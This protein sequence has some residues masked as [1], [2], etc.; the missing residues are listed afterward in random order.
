M[1]T[2]SPAQLAAAW[3]NLL[4]H[5]A[6][7]DRENGSDLAADLVARLL[8]PT[9]SADARVNAARRIMAADGPMGLAYSSARYVMRD[10]AR[11]NRRRMARTVSIDAIGGSPEYVVPTG[12]AGDWHRGMADDAA[13]D[14]A[15]DADGRIMRADRATNESRERIARN[16]ATSAGMMADGDRSAAATA[17]WRAASRDVPYMAERAGERETRLIREPSLATML[18]RAMRPAGHHYSAEDPAEDRRLRAAWWETFAYRPAPILRGKVAQSLAAMADAASPDGFGW[19]VARHYSTTTPRQQS[20]RMDTRESGEIAWSSLL[21]EIGAEPTTT[22]VRE[23]RRMARYAAAYATDAVRR[24]RIG[25]PGIDPRA[26][27]TYDGPSGAIPASGKV[28]TIPAWRAALVG[29]M[30]PT[31]VDVPSPAQAAAR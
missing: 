23:V 31:S 26:A 20:G 25:S 28:A 9:D 15:L 7:I 13:R 1:P 2:P 5:A 21:R 4:S 17:A 29:G 10:A 19:L 11:S 6:T 27:D 18:D 16:A 8:D 14:A 30:V 3:P 12:W 22:N 24:G